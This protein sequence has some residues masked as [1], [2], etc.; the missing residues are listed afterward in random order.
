MVNLGNPDGCVDCDPKNAGTIHGL[1]AGAQMRR[2]QFALR[3][4]F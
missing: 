2:F 3:F 4:E 1:R